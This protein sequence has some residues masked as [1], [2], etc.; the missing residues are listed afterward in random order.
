MIGAARSELAREAYLAQVEAALTQFVGEALDVQVLQRFLAASTMSKST[1]WAPTAGTNWRLFST[2]RPA[3][4]R[5]C[6][7]ATSPDCSG[8]SAAISPRPGW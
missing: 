7:L 5:V 1:H 2:R 8:R 6:Y 4:S 3:A